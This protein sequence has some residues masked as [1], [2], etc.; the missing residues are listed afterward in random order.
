MHQIHFHIYAEHITCKWQVQKTAVLL[1]L[2]YVF[3]FFNFHLIYHV[4]CINDHYEI[5]VSVLHFN[6]PLCFFWF[7]PIE[8][9]GWKFVCRCIVSELLSVTANCS[10]N[11]LNNHIF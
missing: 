4:R 9:Y 6:S 1:F 2:V 8:F 7:C 3:M 11:I 5:N 10:L